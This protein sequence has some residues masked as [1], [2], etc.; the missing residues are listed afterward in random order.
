MTLFYYTQPENDNVQ[1]LKVPGP[2]SK[3]YRIIS[4]SCILWEGAPWHPAYVVVSHREQII[5]GR[6]YVWQTL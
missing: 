2:G 3:L 6:V 1:P 5:S 4:K